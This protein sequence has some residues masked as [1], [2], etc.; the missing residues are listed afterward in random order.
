MIPRIFV[1]TEF[2]RLPGD[3][4]HSADSK[5]IPKDQTTTYHQIRIAIIQLMFPL[6]LVV[7]LV[8]QFRLFLSD[9]A[10]TFD[11][12][13]IVLHRICKFLMNCPYT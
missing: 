13:M 5:S 9:K 6:L 7:Q 11:D 2:S 3:L 12:S 10:W 1:H 4:G 8:L